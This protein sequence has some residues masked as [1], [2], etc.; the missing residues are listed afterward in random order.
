MAEAASLMLRSQLLDG[1]KK[2]GMVKND[3][4]EDLDAITTHAENKLDHRLK[5][6]AR[7]RDC[8]FASLKASFLPIR[9][10]Y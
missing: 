1:Q 5:K 4:L 3:A 10:G 6:L 9:S 7:A 2:T 8:S